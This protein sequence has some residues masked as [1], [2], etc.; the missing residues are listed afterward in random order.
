MCAGLV[1]PTVTE[2]GVCQI[3]S[4]VQ[5]LSAFLSVVSVFVVV[6]L[7]LQLVV[8]FGNVR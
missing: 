2:A 8:L 6:L 1:T 4:Q 5:G 3:S 7:V